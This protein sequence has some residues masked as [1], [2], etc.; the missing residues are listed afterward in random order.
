VLRNRGIDIGNNVLDGDFTPSLK[1]DVKCREQLGGI[2]R[3]YYREK[4]AA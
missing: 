3:D 1:G 4:K 2:I